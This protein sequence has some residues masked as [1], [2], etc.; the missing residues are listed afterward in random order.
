MVRKSSSP[1][2]FSTD[3]GCGGEGNA[4]VDVESAPLDGD[5]PSSAAITATVERE[6]LK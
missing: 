5:A 2:V 6:M 3:D 1:V 4:A